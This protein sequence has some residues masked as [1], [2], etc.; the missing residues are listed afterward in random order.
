MKKAKYIELLLVALLFT[1]CNLDKYPY[2]EVAADEYVKDASSVNNLVIGC[3]NSLQN[4]MYYEWAMTELRSD[5]SRM[6]ATGSSASTTKLVEQLD[7]GTIIAEHQWVENYWDACYATIARANNVISY[8]DIIEDG[9]LRK[10]YEGEALFL[11]SLE[12]FNLVRLWG[13]VFIVTSKIPSNI[14]R[15]MQRST[16]NEVYELIEGDL[17]NVINNQMLPEK[18]KDVDM[19]RA[20]INAAKA[21]LAKVYATHYELGDTQYA[22][23][24]E[25]CKE[26]LK[27]ASV[28]NPQTG[29]DLVAY[30]QIFAIT[31][32]MNKEIIFAVR[33]RSGNLGLGSPFGNMF[34]PVNNGANVI[35]GTSSGY[36]TPSDNI[37]AAYQSRGGLDKR[38][39]VNIAQKYF[40][41]TTQEW[42]T[43]G[44]CRYCKKY[45]N[46]VSTEYDGESDW[47]I[48]RVGDIALLY[49]ELTNEISGPSDDNLKYLN[50][51]CERAGVS[52]YTLTDLSNRYNFREAVRNERRLELAF[53]NQRWF[54][55]LRWGVA[56]QTVNN[57]FKNE[58]FYSEY[59]YKVND[60]ANWQTFLPIPVSIVNINP[61]VAQNTGY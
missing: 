40:N 6:Y 41:S 60:I 2:S 27:S 49:A 36:N 23:A 45:T 32:E 52:T 26:V 38:L 10:Q 9:T 4:V 31:N 13:P 48:I 54:D 22:R 8:L 33:Y 47:P 44:N 17:E 37:I 53:E 55:L 20:D 12:Y 29:A 59:T 28:G 19:G 51:I 3:Y 30:N 1:A 43:T 15:N 61:D 58:S 57:Y 5:D 7:Q 34:A 42:V 11:R 46:A 16:V 21:L 14:A 24:A 25:L 56:A 39:D 50:M 18:M 35:I